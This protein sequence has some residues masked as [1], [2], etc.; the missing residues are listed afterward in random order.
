MKGNPGKAGQ[1]VTGLPTCRLS[2]NMVMGRM[3]VL[4]AA[5]GLRHATHFIEVGDRGRDELLADAFPV[6]VTS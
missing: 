1:D 3:A 2:S 4:S 5:A 6:R